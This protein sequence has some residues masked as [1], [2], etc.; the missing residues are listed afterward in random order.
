MLITF[1]MVLN[2]VTGTMNIYI[3]FTMLKPIANVLNPHAWFSGRKERQSDPEDRQTAVES[4]AQVNLDLRVILGTVRLTFDHLV[5]L[6]PG[7]VIS[8]DTSVNQDVSMV[9]ANRNC[10][11]VRVGKVGN[12]IAAQVTSLVRPIIDK[13]S[14]NPSQ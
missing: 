1:E 12:R 3:P 4:L 13:G 5:N 11:K 14:G 9:V 10:F 7:D 2:S 8:L 6:K